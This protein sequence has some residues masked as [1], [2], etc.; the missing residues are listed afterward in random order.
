MGRLK[1]QASAVQA[2][3]ADLDGHCA[4]CC[5]R[6][7]SPGGERRRIPRKICDREARG[8]F[9]D[10]LYRRLKKKLYG[11]L[12]VRGIDAVADRLCRQNVGKHLD[13]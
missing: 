10:S 11:A 6:P 3:A 13:G 9:L 1:N 8:R 12:L 7:E 2:A 4:P 5:K